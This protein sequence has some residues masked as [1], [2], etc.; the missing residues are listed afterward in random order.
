MNRVRVG[1][2]SCGV[3]AGGRQ[4]ARAVEAAIREQ[5]LAVDQGE[6]GCLGMCYREVLVELES[7]AM[8]RCLY[9][10]VTAENAPQLLA[11]HFRDRAV[12]PELL[13][14]RGDDWVDDFVPGQLRIALRNCGRIDPRSLDDYLE[15]GGYRALRRALAELEPAQVI[16][17]IEASGLRGR[18]GG[19]FSTGRKWHLARAAPGAGKVIICNAD[20][21]DPGAFMDRNL[22]EGDPFSVLEG[23]TIAAYA[24]GATRGIIYVRD[25]YPLA[26]TRLAGALVQA[27][28]RGLLGDGIAGTGFSLQ[29]DIKRGA[30]AFVCGEETA[31]IAALEGRRGMPRLRPPFPVESGLHGLPTVINNVE[32][33]ANVP[34]IVDQGA[35][36]FH[37][38]GVGRSRGTKVFSLAG[39]VRRTGMVEVPMG[40]SIADIVDRIGGGPASGRAIKAVQ[41]GGPAGG[42]L[43]ASVFATTLVDYESLVDTGAIMGSGGLVVMDETTCMVDVARYFLAFC[44]DESCGKCTFCRIGTRRMLEIMDR[45]CA[46]KGRAADLTALETLAGQVKGNSLCGLGKAAPNPVLS[47]L[48]WFRDEYQA[49]LAGRCPAGR[50]RQLI[51]FAIDPVLCEG[52]TLCFDQC[53]IEAIHLHPRH[54]PLAIDDQ[55]CLRCAGCF[56]TCPYQ[57]VAVS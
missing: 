31:M 3:A 24:I 12:V 53:A 9:G 17:A 47:T 26:A 10:P 50:C 29:V 55:V 21:G 15:R 14:A 41:I 40:T 52:C 11:A 5:A 48:R 57:A 8:G 16:D 30:G 38:H 19:G 37:A 13:V 49:H 36:A 1:L 54:I 56:Q 25:E 32:T 7:D 18:G 28:A 22:I 2:G 43:P 45:L 20:E 4:V 23:M 27:R 33:F 6:T 51:R 46:G 34:W 42:C 44:A 35:D 39:D